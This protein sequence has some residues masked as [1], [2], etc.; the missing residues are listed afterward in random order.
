MNLTQERLAALRLEARIER[1]TVLE[2][3]GREGED[4]STVIESVPSVD[5]FVVRA[6]RDE[7]LE[8]RGLLA[9]F[10]LARVAARSSGP[11][12]SVHRSNADRVEFDLLR[13]I[14][15]EAPQ[16]TTAVWAF[17]DHLEV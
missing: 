3:R 16:L 9:E 2:H 12:A 5:E 10:A 11:D 14:A 1:D 17:A 4:P 13:E 8:E 7:M 15:A 6:L